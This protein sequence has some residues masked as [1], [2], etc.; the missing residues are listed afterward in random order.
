MAEETAIP[1]RGTIVFQTSPVSVTTDENGI[2]HKVYEPKVDYDSANFPLSNPSASSNGIRLY[3]LFKAGVGFEEDGTV[4][5]I[6]Y[7]CKDS[8]KSI[9]GF[10]DYFLVGPDNSVTPKESAIGEDGYLSPE[11]VQ[12]ISSH[13]SDLAKA[14]DFPNDGISR[15]LS[16]DRNDGRLNVRPWQDTLTNGDPAVWA[17]VDYDTG[18]I[19]FHELPFGYYFISSNVGSVAVINSTAPV[20]N[21]TDK[22]KHSNLEKTITQITNADG[23]VTNPDGEGISADIQPGHTGAISP[24]GNNKPAH[25]GTVQVGDTVEYTVHI[26]VG[27]GASADVFKIEDIMSPGL[28]LKEE[29]VKLLVKSGDTKT[30]LDSANYNTPVITHPQTYDSSLGGYQNCTKIELTFKQ[31]YLDTIENIADIYLVYDCVI[32][33]KAVIAWDSGSAYNGY[34]MNR[35]TTNYNTAIL[36]Y[37]RTGSVTDTDRFYSARLKIF[38]YEGDGESLSEGAKPLN[39]VEFVLKNAE[40]KFLAVGADKTIHWVDQ[41][42]DAKVLVSGSSGASEEV[43][44]TKAPVQYPPSGHFSPEIPYP[45]ADGIAG[46]ADDYYETTDVSSN[47]IYK[48]YVGPD[49]VKDTGDD[50]VNIVAYPPYYATQQNVMF[51]I[52]KSGEDGTWETDDDITISRSA[53]AG[54]ITIDGLTN[55]TYT[56]VETKSLPGY[57]KAEDTQIVINNQNNTLNELKYQVNVVN[58]PGS[59]LPS[60]GG[61][62][63][64]IFYVIGTVLL[65][66]SG[67]ILNEKRRRNAA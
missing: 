47:K 31:S 18:I 11:A 21:I 49:A 66:G 34:D 19:T 65:I 23:V 38:K 32:N 27:K 51:L 50:I 1:E 5:G 57:N 55:G 33:Q 58:K 54:M 56:L 61:S 37:G 52:Q 67:I 26:T 42:A 29:S 63:T 17:S 25:V 14:Y 15:V 44:V 12:W 6:V 35:P 43:T 10:T 40:G 39:G 48:I 60:T 59:V 36:T 64:T 41:Q 20:V 9:P 28:T 45:G 53:E 46:T 22:N 3:L 2:E 62:G 8:H 4:K 24:S 30:I 13:Y 7:Y 16:S